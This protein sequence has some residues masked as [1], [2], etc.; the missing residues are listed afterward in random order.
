MTTTLEAPETSPRAAAPVASRPDLRVLVVM[1]LAEQRGGSEVALLHLMQFGHGQGVTW[2]VAFLSPG[3]MVQQ[4][5]D[6]GVEAFV[7]PAGRLRE[8]HRMAG[9]IWRLS[10]IVRS[11]RFDAVLSWMGQPHL[12]G[13]PA[14]MLARVPALWFQHGRASDGVWQDRLATLMPA[15]GILACSRSSADGQEQ[16]WPK[17]PVRVVHPGVDLSRFDPE[18]MPPAATLRSQLGLPPSGPI[19]GIVGR[20]QRWKG[21]HHVIAAMPAILAR[22][23]DVTCLLVGGEHA[24]EPDYPDV[25]R[26]QIEA[27]GLSQQVRMVGLQRNVPQ[28]MAATDVILHASEDEPFGI[29]VIEAMALGKPVV[30]TD[31]GGPREIITDG[32]DGLLWQMGN[33]DALSTAVLRCLDDPAMASRLGE[34]ARIRAAAFSTEQYASN[35]AETVT[36][37]LSS[38]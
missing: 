31:A 35:V 37:F 14:A 16:L 15:R 21:F 19:I 20:L 32:V 38:K 13:G 7:V 30:A 6:L 17:R 34:Q 28:W 26:R 29:V 1:P 18:Q 23:P 36:E 22:H 25:L 24:L 10:R 3:P 33:V 11:G 8:P 4:C 12:Y 2:A 27:A 5:A 9:A